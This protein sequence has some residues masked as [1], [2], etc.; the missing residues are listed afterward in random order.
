LS[1]VERDPT[2]MFIFYDPTWVYEISGLE[3]VREHFLCVNKPE[4]YEL[5]NN[6]INFHK[7]FEKDIPLINTNVF[8]G[9]ACEYHN[10]C[11]LFGINHAE[12]VIQVPVS[13]GGHG[14]FILNS[15]SD[16][17][18]NAKLDKDSEYLV[19]LYLK[20]NLP[21]NI[22][23]VIFD[24]DIIFLPG[25][26][27]IIRNASDSIIYR[28]ADYITYRKLPKQQQE[29]F[30]I[31]SMKLCS[32]LRES[33]YRGIC[34]IDAIICENTVYIMELN[35]RFQGSTRILNIG[36]KENG[37]RTLQEMNFD[38][39]YG[40][41][42]TK[43]KTAKNTQINYS[44]YSYVNDADKYHRD[45]IISCMG[46]EKNIFA[47]DF[48]GL[49]NLQQLEHGVHMFRTV[50]DTNICCLNEDNGLFHHENICEPSPF[51]YRK[52][53]E[54]DKLAL[55]I[56][57]MTQG[58][59]IEDN[60][61]QHLK[62]NGGIRPGNNNAIDIKVCGMIVNAP[63]DIKFANL[64]P[65]RIKLEQNSE[66]S[67]FYYNKMI[68]F[69]E[70]YPLDPLENKITKANGI[71]YSNIAY[72]S[73]DRL[74]VHMTNKCIY[75][76]HGKSCSFCNINMLE[77]NIIPLEDIEEVI[78]DYV[79]N[80]PAARHFLVGGQS[81]EEIHEKPRI[82]DIIKI[83]RKETEKR[84]YV[85]TLPFDK[86]AIDEMIANGMNELACNME[87]FDEQLAIKYM[88]GKGSI[89]R[90]KYFDVLTYAAE[91]LPNK[92][93][94]RCA[95]I[96]GLEPYDS[97]LNGI[98]RLVKNNI[99]PV[100]SV[101]R[102]LP[103]TSLADLVPPPMMYLYK[104]YNEVEKLC[105]KHGLRLGPSCVNCQNNTLSLPK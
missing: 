22:H 51:L 61:Q 53:I 19:S 88:P 7:A 67:L 18:V 71:P 13:N 55:K 80:S 78:H 45:N 2:T 30:E 66:L 46:N 73:T 84:I 97:L 9:D 94:V 101:F 26:V 12:F 52:T 56:A 58:V 62:K 87:I 38:A 50:F 79:K 15:K 64:T 36:L 20:N 41:S 37:Y 40:N 99:E 54:K 21:V 96:A 17:R 63:R 6:K 47:C 100:I 98:K 105:E 44:C 86:D 92:G 32:K 3:A 25:S 68:S 35:S 93:D 29:S 48:D 81:A 5:L 33:G 11:K 65:F 102:P 43:D 104:L 39:F 10:L 27:Q 77:G 75:K 76:I 82:I 49:N 69:I 72:L 24:K 57:L 60:A 16:K 14:T 4:I 59:I 95:L 28:G 85:M 42:D 70:L 34:G 83:I 90:E 91:I 1:A 8:K 31:N 23:A 103:E 74:R 89:S